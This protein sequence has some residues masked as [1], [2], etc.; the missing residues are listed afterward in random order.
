MKKTPFLSL[1]HLT[2]G[3]WLIL[4]N[5]FYYC[6]QETAGLALFAFQEL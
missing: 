4:F 2:S 3:G 6:V 1:G 5:T